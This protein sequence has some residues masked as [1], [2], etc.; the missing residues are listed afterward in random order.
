MDLIGIYRAFHP[1]AEKYTFFSSAHG[2]F[3]RIEQMLG[4]KASVGKFKKTEII[5]S[6]FSDHNAMRL[7]INYRKKK[8]VKNHKYVETKHYVTKQPMDH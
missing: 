7:E 5:S 3:S 4:H 1:K 6:V 2:T 8:T